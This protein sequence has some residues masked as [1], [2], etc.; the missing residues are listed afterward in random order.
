MAGRKRQ[1]EEEGGGG[2]PGW[3]VTYGDMMSLL[4]TFFVLLI[5][6]SSIKQEDFEKAIASLQGALGVLKAEL[7]LIDFRRDTPQ[8]Q[9]QKFEDVAAKI[10]EYIRVQGRRED[11]QVRHTQE[12]L[13]L[14]MQ[15]PVL[16]DTG[17]D[18]LKPEAVPILTDIAGLLSELSDNF[19]SVE[20]HTDNVPIRTERFPSNLDLSAARALSVARF[21]ID[22]GGI[23]YKNVSMRG[24][25]ENLPLV[26]NNSV[27]NR[28]KNRRVD[29]HVLR[30]RPTASGQGLV[31][32]QSGEIENAS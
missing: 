8:M 18:S 13:K 14:T 9:A 6:F 29:V 24:Y 1:Q 16:F 19:I 31:H 22:R 11:I 2:A 23:D 27:E 7:T 26:P 12:G 10:A 30:A 15:N 3:M 17:E 20:G 28:Q 5:S 21:I 32:G 25:G 4:L